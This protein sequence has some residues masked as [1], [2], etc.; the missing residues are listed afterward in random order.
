[1]TFFAY[2]LKSLKDEIHYYGST[3]N[4][5][6]RLKIHNSGKSK[7]TKG[8]RPWKIIYS[9]KFNTRSEAMMRELFFKSVDGNIWLKEK[10]II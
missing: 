3:S 6:N 5:E 1:M 10:R 7:F 9:E 4:L 2:I 8:H